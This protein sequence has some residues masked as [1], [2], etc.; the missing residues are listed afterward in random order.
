MWMVARCEA[1]ASTV[2][3]VLDPSTEKALNDEQR[4]REAFACDERDARSRGNDPKRDD[5]EAAATDDAETMA[6][7]GNRPRPYFQPGTPYEH[8]EPGL[9][10]G[11]QSAL[12]D[13]HA[14]DALPGEN[15]QDW[16][17]A[18]DTRRMRGPGHAAARI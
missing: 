13:E 8:Y 4:G 5:S 11:W 2:R 1:T 18:R 15:A 14:W 10:Y 3:P 9:W 7:T 6:S 12:G 17:E 16:E